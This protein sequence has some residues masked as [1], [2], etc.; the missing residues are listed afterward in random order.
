M[1]KGKVSIAR[2]RIRNMV[3][4][5]LKFTAG[6]IKSSLHKGT[7]LEQKWTNYEEIKT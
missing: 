2:T 1:H 5:L 3:A 4:F 7:R 6:M